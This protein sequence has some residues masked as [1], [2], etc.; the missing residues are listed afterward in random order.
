MKSK[1]SSSSSKDNNSPEALLAHG[2]KIIDTAGKN[3]EKRLEEFVKENPGLSNALK[4]YAMRNRNR[5][6]ILAINKANPFLGVKF[7]F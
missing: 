3:W 1:K 7:K 6:A 5:V 2:K 4:Q